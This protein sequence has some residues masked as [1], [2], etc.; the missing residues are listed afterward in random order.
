MTSLDEQIV[1][2]MVL[3]EQ[4]AKDVAEL[5]L[6]SKH[7][8]DTHHNYALELA[9]VRGELNAEKIRGARTERIVHWLIATTIIA[10]GSGLFSTIMIILR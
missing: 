5:K 7:Q 6:A 4:M 8:S 9:E 2:L 10:L 3:V 1:R